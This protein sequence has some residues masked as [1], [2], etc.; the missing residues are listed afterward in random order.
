MNNIT[1]YK[2]GKWFKH[3]DKWVNQA[4]RKEFLGKDWVQEDKILGI[5]YHSR[6]E[7]ELKAEEMSNL[8]KQEKAKY[9][10]EMKKR[11]IK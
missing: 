9:D 2:I 7:L 6:L 1:L 10:A 3:Y 11:G 8:Y 4:R 5:T